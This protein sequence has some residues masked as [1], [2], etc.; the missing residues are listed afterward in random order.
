MATRLY[1]IIISFSLIVLACYILIAEDNPSITVQNPTLTQFEQLSVKAESGLLCPCSNFSMSYARILSLSAR[2]H[3]IC[4]SDCLEDRWFAYFSHAHLHFFNIDFRNNGL[5]FFKLIK[6]LCQLSS[7]TIEHAIKVLRMNRLVTVYALSQQEFSIRIQERL[8]LFQRE[9]NASFS[10]PIESM[11][12]MM[13]TN[14]VAEY[15]FTNLAPKGIYDETRSRRVPRL[16]SRDLYN[17]SCSCLLSDQCIRSVGFTLRMDNYTW[18]NTRFLV[19]GLVFGCFATDYVLL[20]TLE[21]FFDQVCLNH[22]MEHRDFDAVDLSKPLNNATRSIEPLSVNRTRFAPQTPI[23]QIFSQLFIE[24]WINTT[25]FTAY[26]ARCSPTHCTY[27]HRQRFRLA[28]MIAMMLGFAGSL[29]KLL[30]IILPFLVRWI[31]RFRDRFNRMKDNLHGHTISPFRH[32]IQQIQQWNHFPFHLAS[33]TQQIIAS[34]IY[35][36]LVLSGIVV[37]L[38]YAGPF[39]RTTTLVAI[40]NPSIETI[41]HLYSR[42]L[43]SSSCSCSKVTIPYAHFLSIEVEFDSICSNPLTSLSYQMDLLQKNTS[44]FT[45][46]RITHSRLLSSLCHLS[47]MFVQHQLDRFVKQELITDEPWMNTTFHKQIRSKISNFIRQTKSEY[48]RTLFFITR[49]FHANHFVNLFMKNWIIDYSNKE[50]HFILRSIPYYFT[51]S[52]CTCARSMDCHERVS[53]DLI[54]ACFPCDGFRFSSDGQ[55]NRRLFIN[56]WSHQINYSGYVEA[57]RPQ[58]CQYTTIDKNNPVT[59]FATLLSIYAG[60]AKSTSRFSIGLITFFPS[61]YD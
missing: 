52:N 38:L 39:S 20:S 23:N 44:N 33:A 43:S 10:H 58:Q 57:C 8:A 14:Q 9:T 22:L 6:R 41:H 4:S 48:R 17:N 50:E 54:L 1:L 28:T 46:E 51:A 36:L 26:F 49:S 21:C 56:R 40:R 34:R 30:E 12:S 18:D 53:D 42:N 60:K 59:V 11:R 29:S 16:R 55:L 13:H 7:E 5:S 27:N 61:R 19:P 31:R 35:V 37:V 47:K 24:E 45:T 2:F 15:L 32:V 3:P 25:N